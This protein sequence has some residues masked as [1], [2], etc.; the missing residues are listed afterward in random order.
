MKAIQNIITK[1]YVK[2]KKSYGEYIFTNDLQE[3]KTYSDIGSKTC[4][5]TLRGRINNYSFELIDVEL[6]IKNN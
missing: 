1:E 6:K 2:A 3:A 5:K 4:L